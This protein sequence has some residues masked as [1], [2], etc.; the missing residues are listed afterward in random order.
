MDK[1]I[2]DSTPPGTSHPEKL[3]SI[4]DFLVTLSI[5]AAWSQ[6]APSSSSLIMEEEKMR[7]AQL[8]LLLLQLLG[9]FLSYM[10]GNKSRAECCHFH[11][12]V[13]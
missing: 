2:A 7:W 9:T 4:D 1:E 3:S 12:A 11:A 13:K 5:L 6:T 10:F 8:C